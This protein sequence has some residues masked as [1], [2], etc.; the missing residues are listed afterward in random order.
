MQIVHVLPKSPLHYFFI[1]REK[2]S[3][4]SSSGL[5]VRLL[6]R[7]G[8]R[9]GSLRRRRV[10]HPLALDDLVVLAL[11]LAQQHLRLALHLLHERRLALRL[12]ILRVR[13]L[14][15]LRRTVG[16][17]LRRTEALLALCG[18]R[19]GV[20]LRLFAGVKVCRVVVC[21]IAGTLRSS[22]R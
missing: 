18:L 2:T 20:A 16:V 5:S 10:L 1:R 11:D 17:G 4:S 9:V 19:L 13:R 21:V 3:T 12:R 7:R 6:R 8:R 22:K 15:L 14:L